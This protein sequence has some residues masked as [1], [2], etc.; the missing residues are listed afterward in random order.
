MSGVT[1]RDAQVFDPSAFKAGSNAH[2]WKVA[3][4]ALKVLIFVVGIAVLGGG[5]GAG[6]GYMMLSSSPWDVPFIVGTVFAGVASIVFAPADLYLIVAGIR[7]FLAIRKARQTDLSAPI[8]HDA[9]PEVI[10]KIMKSPE[11]VSKLKVEEVVEVKEGE[12]PAI[13]P[14]SLEVIMRKANEQFDASNEENVIPSVSIA[15]LSKMRPK[16]EDEDG[17]WKPGFLLALYRSIVASSPEGDAKNSVLASLLIGIGDNISQAPDLLVKII[18]DEI[19]LGG[20][21]RPYFNE[22]GE[23][24]ANIKAE[25]RNDF[26]QAFTREEMLEVLPLLHYNIQDEGLKAEI[27]AKIAED[28]TRFANWV[29]DKTSYFSTNI[30][31]FFIAMNDEQKVAF[32][33]SVVETRRKSVW[34]RLSKLE[35][36]DRGSASVVSAMN[37]Y[38]ELVARYFVYEHFIPYF[39][40][41]NPVQQSEI[42]TYIENTMNV[43]EANQGTDYIFDLMNACLGKMQAGDK[44]TEGPKNFE[45]LFKIMIY[46]LQRNAFND[47]LVDKQKL[48]DDNF[49][50]IADNLNHRAKTHSEYKDLILFIVGT[51][52]FKE[53]EKAEG[54]KYQSLNSVMRRKI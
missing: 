39:M 20:E 4:L 35:F 28:G 14:L 7:D 49:K 43:D 31:T 38:P 22:L 9:P 29:S 13:Q 11:L 51:D 17:N 12:A 41:M 44:P 5:M 16:L 42:L 15:E 25:A 48:N 47:F 6:G 45:A 26:L 10:N 18:K 36:N 40:G 37:S 27:A 1:R 32:L 24:Y 19:P 3:A 52:R 53:L 21:Q 46:M 30:A 2:S 23:F 33:Q 34:K 50:R 54:D 8:P